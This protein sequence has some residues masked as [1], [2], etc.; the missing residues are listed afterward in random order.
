MQFKTEI[1]RLPPKPSGFRIPDHLG[2]VP[3]TPH[4][5][6]DYAFVWEFPSPIPGLAT[7][8]TKIAPISLLS[9]L[10]PREDKHK[11][12]HLSLGEKFRLAHKLANCVW[13]LSKV[14]CLHRNISSRSIVFFE[15]EGGAS[16]L[17]KTVGNPYLV[18]FQHPRMAENTGHTRQTE[19]SASNTSNA[20]RH[21][22]H[23]DC[24][25][26]TSFRKIYDYY[27]TSIV[28]LEL[29]SWIPLDTYQRHN[30][31]IL[32]D[33]A[34]FHDRLVSTYVPR[35]SRRL[36]DTYRDVTL[37]CL[38]SDFGQDACSVEGQI[39]L[40]QFYNKVVY[41]LRGLSECPI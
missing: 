2:Y 9:L 16:T 19:N 25:S 20:L 41:P 22:Q 30:S 15:Q 27:S 10:Q 5:A 29:G 7:Q 6:K 39:V 36:G 13:E 18:N 24:S 38:R 26:S 12:I 4:T 35:L 40:R 11:K 32:S 21:D 8:Q 14:G 17:S 23:P 31:K 34:A 3:S 1:F 33:H 37:A 28:L